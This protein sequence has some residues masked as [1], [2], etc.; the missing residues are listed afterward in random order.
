MSTPVIDDKPLVWLGN[1]LEDLQAFPDEVKRGVGYALRFAQGGE[2][3]PDAKPL[4]GY[5][6]AGV[7]EV[8]E[9]FMGDTYRAVYTV[10][11][12]GIVYVLHAFQ[13]KSRQGIKTPPNEIA[14]VDRRLR[15]ATDHYAEWSRQQAQEQ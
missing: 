6:G 13:K 9:D 1:S 15:L 7:L 12:S 14:R 4:Q 5:K 10:R 3:H 11:F 8:I 2:K